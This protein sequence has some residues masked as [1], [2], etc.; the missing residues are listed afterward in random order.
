MIIPAAEAVKN[1]R[2]GVMATQGTI[3]SGA[4]ERE[5]KK[6]NPQAQIFQQA[7]PGL[8]DA[9]ER[10]EYESPKVKELLKEYL[11]PLIKKEINTLILGCTHY[12]FLENEIREVVGLDIEIISEGKIVAEKLKDYL[13]RHPEMENILAENSKIEFLTTDLSNKFK[14]LGTVFFGRP[15]SPKKISL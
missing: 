15:I 9:I 4:F 12:G 5:L 3:N 10:G 8:V 6:L 11:N 13:E 14:I 7:C 1:M 2:I